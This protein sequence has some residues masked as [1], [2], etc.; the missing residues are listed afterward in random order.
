MDHR[1]QSNTL[2]TW[3]FNDFGLT[4]QCLCNH[5]FIGFFIYNLIFSHTLVLTIYKMSA[6]KHI[7]L[8]GM[9]SATWQS[10]YSHSQS[11]D[12]Y[13]NNMMYSTLRQHDRVHFHWQLQWSSPAI[14]CTFPP[15]DNPVESLLIVHYSQ[16]SSFPIDNPVDLTPT[17]WCTSS[18]RQS[19]GGLCLLL[20]RQSSS[21]HTLAI[22]WTS[23][24]QSGV[25]FFSNKSA[26]AIWCISLW[27]SSEAFKFLTITDNPVTYTLH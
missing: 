5:A 26:S 16:R 7:S 17:T 4:I 9:V 20:Y 18:L 21:F 13:I 23:H 10:S 14:W 25:Y 2:V 3:L 6:G 1:R 27:R 19:D 15:S 12:H 22:Q 24:Q 11:H 8:T